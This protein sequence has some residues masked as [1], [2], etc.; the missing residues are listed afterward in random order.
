MSDLLE[1]HALWIG[2]ELPFYAAGCLSSFARM[3]H[4]VF[5]H[6]Y[7]PVKNVPDQII[8]RDAA[9]I[10]PT[11]KIFRHQ[12]SGSYAVFSDYFR[13]KLL[14]RGA[15]IWVDCDAYCV[16]PLELNGGYL[17]AWE[18]DNSIGNGVLHLPPS[19]PIL[20]GLLSIFETSPERPP[21][22]GRISWTSA[23]MR[24][25]ITKSPLTKVLP[26]GVTGPGALTWLT[27]HHN[28][29]PFVQPVDV[30]Y[31][32]HWSLAALLAQANTP[33]S[34][35]IRPKTRSIHLFNEMIRRKGL[36]AEPGSLLARIEQEGKTGRPAI[37]LTAYE[38]II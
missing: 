14:E 26:W 32:V 19:S 16:R 24:A 7:D 3:G 13:C 37:E 36:V 22:V 9:A 21:W 28:M 15:G 10:V 5:L 11:E 30:L 18:D 1:C 2:K 27:R 23:W 17:A 31:P 33:T 34:A 20:Q 4:K 38:N 6:V 8:V 12:S 25:V 35:Y 29:T